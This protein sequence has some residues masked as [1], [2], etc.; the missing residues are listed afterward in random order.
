MFTEAIV[1]AVTVGIATVVGIP[2]SIL[3]FGGF[4]FGDLL[5]IIKIVVLSPSG[6][7]RARATVIGEITV[8][9][10]IGLGHLLFVILP[11][12]PMEML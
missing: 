3:I 12:H 7:P 11:L 1:V 10:I 9:V 8:S 5:P 6:C 2:S 4:F